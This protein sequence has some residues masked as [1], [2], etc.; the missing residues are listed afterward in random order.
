M[1][2][3][4][5]R[6]LQAREC[7]LRVEQRGYGSKGRLETGK[8]RG[9]D[10]I[11][12][13]SVSK[14]GCQLDS[15]WGGHSRPRSASPP[16]QPPVFPGLRPGLRHTAWGGSYCAHTISAPRLSAA[17]LPIPC[18]LHGF[19][20]LRDR[21]LLYQGGTIPSLE[22][23]LSTGSCSTRPLIQ[24]ALN[25]APEEVCGGS[26]H[27]AGSLDYKSYGLVSRIAPVDRSNRGD[28]TKRNF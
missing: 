12:S 9:L 3:P 4:P 6:P 21:A 10:W 27:R 15:V 19:C 1:L 28:L 2:P 22:K 17:V 23:G 13:A 18:L 14:E 16:S 25:S 8:N 26:R 24:Q 7:R 20:S 11:A 5:R